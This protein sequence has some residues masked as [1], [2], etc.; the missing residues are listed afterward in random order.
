MWC[1]VGWMGIYG[2]GEE[3][4]GRPMS[5]SVC[6]W[7]LYPAVSRLDFGGRVHAL[8]TTRTVSI[9]PYRS[10]VVVFPRGSSHIKTSFMYIT[11]DLF[12]W[13]LAFPG[14]I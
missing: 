10:L 1:A 6:M 3:R 11:G 4:A 8:C 14:Q 13:I 5:L 2:R 9:M 12:Q 7:D